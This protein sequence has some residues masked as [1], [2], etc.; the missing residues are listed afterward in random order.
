MLKPLK[1]INEDIRPISVDI[2]LVS[3]LLT[4]ENRGFFLKFSGGIETEDWLE[5]R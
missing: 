1:V 5:M 4:L 2:S 3:L